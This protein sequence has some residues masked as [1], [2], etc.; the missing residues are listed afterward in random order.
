MKM[1]TINPKNEITTTYTDNTYVIA[2]LL[3]LLFNKTVAGSKHIKRI[4]YNYNYSNMQKI[5]FTFDNGYK[6]EFIDIPTSGPLLNDFEIEKILK[7]GK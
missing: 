1:N 3:G 5:T 6:Q 2:R 7:G 4:T